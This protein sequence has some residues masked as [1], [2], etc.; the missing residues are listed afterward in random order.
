[1]K[2]FDHLKNKNPIWIAASH[3]TENIKSI[4][5]SCKQGAGA[6]V[7]KG[8]DGRAFQSCNRKCQK[9]K[10]PHSFK[11]RKLFVKKALIYSFTP[12]SLLC[13]F[14]SLEELRIF[15]NFLKENYPKVLR[16]VNISAR[17]PQGLIKT[18]KILKKYGAQILE[19]NTKYTIRYKDTDISDEEYAIFFIR[20]IIEAIKLPLIIKICSEPFFLNENFLR[21]ISRYVSAL[22]ITDSLSRTLPFHLRKKLPKGIEKK[23]CAVVG[24]SLWSLVKKYIPIAKHYV[25]F[26]SASGG[27][28][29]SERAKEIIK[30]GANSIQLCSG[31]ELFGYNL[32]N[33]IAK[34][35]KPK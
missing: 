33:S 26:V 31:I 12:N 11:G 20:G 6:I 2:Y 23:T 10:S 8:T 5:E 34:E 30:L 9:C 3:L 4:E 17:S 27:I 7:L 32:I 35:L 15:L 28:Y 25:N 29:N 18:A 22:T 1:M 19:L 14:L 16:I 21:K 13:E 24:T